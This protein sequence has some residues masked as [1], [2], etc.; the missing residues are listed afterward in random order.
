[1]S[2]KHKAFIVGFAGD[3]ALQ[4]LVQNGYGDWGLSEYFERHGS[5]EA[6]FIAGGMMYAAAYVHEKLTG[7]NEPLSLFVYGAA[8]DVAFRYGRIFPSLDGYYAALTPVESAIWG[9]LPMVMPLF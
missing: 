9:G 2:F 6:M 3:A 7:G 5:V 4:L 1:M 8:V